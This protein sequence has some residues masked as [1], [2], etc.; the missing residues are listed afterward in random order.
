[1]LFTA[2]RSISR[3][4]PTCNTPCVSFTSGTASKLRQYS[5]CLVLMGELMILPSRGEAAIGVNLRA[6]PR[7]MGVQGGSPVGVWGVPNNLFS[8]APAGGWRERGEKWGDPTP[9]KGA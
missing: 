8:P 1:M 7:P 2:Q 3:K 4:Y 5:T 9:P 6:C